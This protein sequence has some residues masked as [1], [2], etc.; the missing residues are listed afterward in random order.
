MKEYTVF[1]LVEQILS[2]FFIY[3]CSYALASGRKL[4]SEK[5]TPKLVKWGKMQSK[6]LHFFL[7]EQERDEGVV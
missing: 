5:N 2:E 7:L 4:K 3:F 1:Y 6:Y